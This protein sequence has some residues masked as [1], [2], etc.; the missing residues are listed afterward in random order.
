MTES[1][2]SIETSLALRTPDY[3]AS[4]AKAVFGVA[5]FVGNLLGEL[6]GVVIP[7]QCS[8]RIVKFAVELERRL[9]SL[10]VRAQDQLRTN[11]HFGE[12]LEE[13]LRQASRSLSDERRQYIASVIANTLTSDAIAHEESRHLLRILGELNDIEVIWLRFYVG[14]S[15]S[16]DKEFRDKHREILR[17]IS[18]SMGQPQSE[19]D[20]AALQDSYKQHLL[21]L[22][23]LESEATRSGSTSDRINYRLTALGRLLLRQVGLR[24]RRGEA[25]ENT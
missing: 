20:R 12:L 1:K 15:T 21:Q 16:D 6:V 10:E 24:A 17:P 19:I 18:R 8:D 23:L 2:E 22:G 4:A 13:G 25:A 3:V 11:E 9:V 14:Q 7:N 5:P